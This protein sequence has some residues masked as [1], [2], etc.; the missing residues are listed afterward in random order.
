M[1]LRAQN[2]HEP[3]TPQQKYKDKQRLPLKVTV[4]SGTHLFLLQPVVPVH[5]IPAL[6]SQE[7]NPDFWDSD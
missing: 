4:G 7:L 5:S 3:E 2:F 1:N 6:D